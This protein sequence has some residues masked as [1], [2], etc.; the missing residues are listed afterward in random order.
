MTTERAES[1]LTG[2]LLAA[3]PAGPTSHDVVAHV[4][5]A[6][7]ERRIGH[8]GTL[9]PFAEGLLV[10]C[11]G[12][13]T[14]LAE[15]FHWLDKS[16]EALVR[17]GV[18]TETH[19]P[20]GAVVRTS[21]AWKSLGREEVEEAL[22]DLTGRIRQRPP[23][24]SAKR[25]GGER[26]HRAARQ[27]R[28]VELEPVAVT[29]HEL[30]LRGFDPPE[31]EVAARVGTGTFLRALARDLGRTLGCGARL[32]SLDR[33]RIG[34]FRSADALP[35]EAIA[36]RFGEEGKS[37]LG[38]AW[39]GPADALPWM[40]SRRLEV[41]EARA[42]RHGT[43]IPAGTVEPPRWQAA[44][45]SESADTHVTLVREGRLLAVAE[46]QGELL[47]PRKVFADAA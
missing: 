15:Y 40:P 35:T 8:T 30:E 43:P 24:F 23:V 42:V 5:R 34:P 13:A 31:L 6:L 18:E 45:L 3:K 20:E 4:R 2:I 41:E 1:A 37:G 33:T 25:V 39:R 14:R 9:D 46:R 27:G 11:V 12:P 17:L 38:A 28:E 47:Q 32:E 7:G 26:A 16:Y 21:D 29:V 36:T 44:D 22:R 19:D 10:L